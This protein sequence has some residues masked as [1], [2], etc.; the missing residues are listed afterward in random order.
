MDATKVKRAADRASFRGLGHAAAAIRL[1]ARRSVRKSKRPSLAGSPPHTRKGQLK[2]A[3]VYAV[4]KG[5]QDAV[6]GPTHELV[7]P[8]AMAHEY[9]GKFRGQN[10]PKRPLM[11]PALE[12]NKDRLPKFWSSSIK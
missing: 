8:S 4:E 12:Q 11:G 10:Y 7:G 2:K 3:I 9:G 5:K 1:T 6:V